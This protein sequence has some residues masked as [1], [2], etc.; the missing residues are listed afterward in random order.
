MK[1]HYKARNFDNHLD[2]GY[3]P[4]APTDD[5]C[6]SAMAVSN[7][8]HDQNRG[9]THFF[10]HTNKGKPDDRVRLVGD[11]ELA[12]S[13]SLDVRSVISPEMQQRLRLGLSNQP[14]SVSSGL[15]DDDLSRS[16]PANFGFERDESVFMAKSQLSRL[17][18]SMSEVD[19]TPAQTPAQT[20]V[21]PGTV[22]SES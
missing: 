22:P 7:H 18:S 1:N 12:M 8:I 20:P 14:R 3:V 10:L 2:N 15:S 13:S 11:V 5:E 17:G 6:K 4:I 9:V 16:I 21:D 19:Q